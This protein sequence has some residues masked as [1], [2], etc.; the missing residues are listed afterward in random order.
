MFKYTS[1]SEQSIKTR[2]NNLELAYRLSRY[3]SY[4]DYISMM[5]DVSLP[6]ESELCN[7]EEGVPHE[8]V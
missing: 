5:T 8:Q 6:D 3:E 2:A 7:T 4:I 1:I